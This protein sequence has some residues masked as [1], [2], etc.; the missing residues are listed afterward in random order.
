MEICLLIY[1]FDIKKNCDCVYKLKEKILFW[2]YI[3]YFS[4]FI[5]YLVIIIPLMIIGYKMIKK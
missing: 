5:L 4:L 2:F 1:L 3:I